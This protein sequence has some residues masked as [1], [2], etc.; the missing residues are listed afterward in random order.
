VETDRA[1]LADQVLQQLQTVEDPELFVDIVNLGLIYGVD[2]NGDKCTISMTL[3]TMGCPLNDYLEA[4]IKKAVLALPE[5]KQVEVKLVWYPVW[6]VDR[7]SAA[8][9]KA[10]GVGQNKVD[11]TAETVSQEKVL[12]L[13]TPI[14]SFADKYPDFVQDM[15]DIG[16]TRI[17]IPGILNTV[18]R[19]M[20][21]KLGA[22]AMG[23]DLTKAK[24]DLEQKGYRIDD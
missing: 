24:H 13:H 9:K 5:I 2:L 4:E 1:K 6:T 7:M 17:T 21:L 22:K 23:F 19:V 8:A 14:K 16:F 12:D 15:Y 3:T 10:L 20:T 18:G 11:Q